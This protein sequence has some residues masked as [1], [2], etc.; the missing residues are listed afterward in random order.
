MLRNII[1]LIVLCLS[2]SSAHAL[3]PDESASTPIQATSS[4]DPEE[5]IADVI[6]AAG[7]KDKLFRL[8]RFRERVLVQDSP[9]EPVKEDEPGNRTSVVV[10]GG[11]WWVGSSKRM[12][13]TAHVLCQAWSLRILLDDTAEFELLPELILSDKPT[14][15]LRVSKATEEPVDLYFDKET[16]Q[17]AAIDYKDSRNLFSEWK[18]TSDG[19]KYP[20]HVIGIRFADRA[21]GTLKDKQWYQTDIL[22]I[23]PLAELPPELK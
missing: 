19:F 22:E 9:A 11:D 12:Y 17:L 16:R 23:T 10:A 2:G 14:T 7:G 1:F 15:G 5:L 6:A 18:E 20:S 21:N 13:E 3:L 4:P 8:F